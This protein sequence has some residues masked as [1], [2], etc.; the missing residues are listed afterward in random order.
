VTDPEVP[1]SL[2]V[3]GLRLWN[4]TM[5]E[6]DL[7]ESELALLQEA[8]RMLD[9]LDIMGATL[10][11]DGPTVTGSRG[12]VRPH[13]LLAEARA[14]RLAVARVLRQLGALEP[15]EEP[16]DGRPMTRSESGRRAA[17]TRWHGQRA[18]AS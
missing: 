9:E 13:P 15:A 12:Q 11:E 1:E 18:V 2:G 5:D 10:V 4:A 3:R 17:I 7:S 6:F 8:S 14:H 16:A